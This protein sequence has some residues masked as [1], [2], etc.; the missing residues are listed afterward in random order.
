M[1]V[2]PLQ[3]SQPMRLCI[4]GCLV[5]LYFI[6]PSAANLSEGR[7]RVPAY[8]LGC[9]ISG[10]G[11][12]QLL[13]RARSTPGAYK[14]CHF[15]VALVFLQIYFSPFYYWWVRLPTEDFFTLNAA[16][17]LLSLLAFP[18]VLLR[19][20]AALSQGAEAEENRRWV[21]IQQLLVVLPLVGILCLTGFN[22][23]RYGTAWSGELS[24]FFRGPWS[25]LFPGWA[26]ASYLITLYRLWRPCRGAE[27]GG[28]LA[29]RA[30]D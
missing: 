16:L 21:H 7:W 29:P 3:V 18:L 11:V 2:S 14:L 6:T 1:N 26:L 20:H 30:L 17:L 4:L 12:I 10:W 8:S 19:I 28:S 22:G 24:E 9:I 25:Q 5:T 23:Y 15:A 27:T 13:I